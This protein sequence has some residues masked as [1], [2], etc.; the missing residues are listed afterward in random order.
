[1][2]YKISP[3]FVFTIEELKVFREAK[4]HNIKATRMIMMELGENLLTLDKMI[5][6]LKPKEKDKV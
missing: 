6:D 2:T 5:E 1:M 3:T 4:M